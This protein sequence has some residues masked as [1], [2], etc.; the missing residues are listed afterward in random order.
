MRGAGNPTPPA[1]SRAVGRIG[2]IS[3]L[4]LSDKYDVLTVRTTRVH[5]YPRVD[6]RIYPYG[7]RVRVRAWIR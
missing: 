6:E 3:A 2:R 7:V 4:G 1:V 5:F